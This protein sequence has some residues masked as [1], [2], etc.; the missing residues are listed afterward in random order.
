M[1]DTVGAWIG[2]TGLLTFILV[3]GA[4]ALVVHT[5]E[6]MRIGMVLTGFALFLIG[7]ITLFFPE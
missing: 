1:S 7:M 2:A 6:D 5:T 3:I 4:D